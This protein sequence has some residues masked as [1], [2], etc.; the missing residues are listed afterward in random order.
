MDGVLSIVATV[1]MAVGAVL[2]VILNLLLL[3][4]R[5][6]SHTYI[7][8]VTRRDGRSSSS[9]AIEP[10]KSFV[11][12][13]LAAMH[14]G[15]QRIAQKT[16]WVLNRGFLALLYARQVPAHTTG[17]RIRPEAKLTLR[18]GLLS[19]PLPILAIPAIVAGIRAILEMRRSPEPVRGKGRARAGIILGFLMLMVTLAAFA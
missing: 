1:V 2:G 17:P 7:I 11:P 12:P 6:R 13:Q 4:L 14:K 16:S 10:K 5:A 19:I 9:H 15:L 3:R 8:G 18:L